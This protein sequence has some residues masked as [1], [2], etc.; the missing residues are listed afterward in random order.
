MRREFNP[1]LKRLEEKGVELDPAILIRSLAIIEKGTAR[2]KDIPDD[3]WKE[4]AEF[5]DSWEKTRSSI[6]YIIRRMNDIGILSSDILPSHNALIPMFVLYSKFSGS[7]N[8]NKVLHWFLLATGDGRYSGSAITTLDQD[9]RTVL[10]SESLNNAIESLITP[11]R[12]ADSFTQDDFRKDYRDEF[13]RLILYLMVFRSQAKDWIY[14]DVKIGY[15][16]SDNKLNEGFKPEW[17]H[18]F[19]K[20]ILKDREI[21][22]TKI[23]VLS[24]IVVL[25]ERANRRFRASPPE[26]YIQNNNVDMERLQEQMVPTNG[27][28]WKIDNYDRFLDERALILATKASEFLTQLK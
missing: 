20:K 6:T 15:D 23:N 14:Q 8:F 10:Q 12:I 4:S 16:R 1:F 22:D 7:F 2:L 18:F 28:F 27:D 11:L 3:F 25:N 26:T 19:P 5:R 21:D 13:L 17:H 24:N 9:V